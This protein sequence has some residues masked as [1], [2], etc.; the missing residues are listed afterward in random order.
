MINDKSALKDLSFFCNGEADIF[1]LIN[2]TTTVKGKGVLKQHILNPPKSIEQLLAVQNVV[3][4]FSSNPNSW[5]NSITNGTLVIIDKYFETADTAPAPSGFNLLVGRFFQ[6]ILAKNE[7]SLVYF[8]LSQLADFF[9]GLNEM[10]LLLKQ[11]N[12]PSK[13]FQIL[14]EIE[15]EIAKQDIVNQ[16]LTVRKYTSF[17]QIVKLNFEARRILKGPVKR[18]IEKYALLDA[19]HAMGL[20]TNANTWVFPE[21][22][23]SFPVKLKAT[24][25]FHPL[26]KQPKSYDIELNNKHNFLLLTGAN[27]SGKTT[28]MRA[29][30]VASLLAHL[31]MGVPSKSMTISFLEGVVT[32]MHIE[33]NLQLGESYFFAEVMRMKQTAFQLQK[34]APH[35]VLMDELFK[36]TNVHDAYDCTSAV[37]NGLLYFPQHILVLSS[38]LFEV[39]QHFVA[40]EKLMFKYFETNITEDG[41]YSFTYELKNGITNDRIGYKILQQEGVLE[42]LKN[43]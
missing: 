33:D 19:W 14:L 1:A 32:N 9:V 37:I 10:T 16:L 39:A 8:S 43:K 36:G 24:G 17:T 3:R 7:Q 4:Y 5:T 21:I 18:L 35:L 22:V 38:H 42:M 28:F 13:L 11:E 41:K 31:G 15:E 26:V 30:G 27:M 20:A 34:K 12:L 6:N 25:L 40:N 2:H 23:S 29:M